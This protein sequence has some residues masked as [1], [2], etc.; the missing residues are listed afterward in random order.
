[1]IIVFHSVLPSIRSVGAVRMSQDSLASQIL[2]QQVGEM[3]GRGLW[4]G[5]GSWLKPF[6]RSEPSRPYY[7][8]QVWSSFEGSVKPFQTSM[9]TLGCAFFSAGMG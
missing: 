6:A 7:V 1:M 9:H 3:W 5:S 2:G 8:A 4:R